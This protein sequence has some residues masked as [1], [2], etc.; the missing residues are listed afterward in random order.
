MGTLEFATRNNLDIRKH[1]LAESLPMEGGDIGRRV[2]IAIMAA[3][4]RQV[5]DLERG[6]SEI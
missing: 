5:R 2:S 1:Y 4:R 6:F 3:K